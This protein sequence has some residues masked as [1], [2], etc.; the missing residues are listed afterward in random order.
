M[1]VHLTNAGTITLSEPTVFNRLDVLVDPQTPQQLEQAIARVG[2]RAGPEHVW[3][4]PSILR[5]LSTHA[6]EAGWE[7]NFDSMVAYASRKGWTNEAGH[8][9]AHLTHRETDDVV[10][11]ADFKSAMRALPAGISAVTSGSGDD[12]VGMIVSS[13]TSISADPPMVGFFAHRNSS[14]RTRLLEQGWFAANVLGEEHREVISHFLSEPQ[15][16]GRFGDGR[17]AE[18]E[19]QVP[20][21][22]DALASLECEIVCTQ[23]IGT[24][25]LVVGKI[26]K[27]A[28]SPA[29]PVVHFNA[30]THSIVPTPAH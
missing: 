3:L 6:G 13:L 18:G 2:G 28:C 19:H 21:L 4:S 1:R 17:W 24:H 20:V 14:I 11:Q 8:L 22:S 29:K 27:A 10:S 16:P 25:D 9:R 7:A 12:K 30:S 26:R 5:F 23:T 15:G